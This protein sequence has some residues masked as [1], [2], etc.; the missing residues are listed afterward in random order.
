MCKV[1]IIS[2]AGSQYVNIHNISIEVNDTSCWAG[3]CNLSCLQFY[4]AVDFVFI[5]KPHMKWNKTLR[6]SG[7]LKRILYL[8]KFFCEITRNQ[9]LFK[10]DESIIFGNF[11]V[12]NSEDLFFSKSFAEDQEIRYCILFTTAFVSMFLKCAKAIYS[13]NLT[14]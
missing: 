2:Y 12:I 13:Y 10:Y 14:A 7:K 4:K 5:C 8:V 9:I 3:A 11:Y 6:I 1:W